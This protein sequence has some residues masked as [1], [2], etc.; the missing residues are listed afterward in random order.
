MAQSR[1]RVAR[2]PAGHHALL[3]GRTARR[4][5]P[6]GARRPGA[7]LRPGRHDRDVG[8]GH[9]AASQLFTGTCEPGVPGG[10]HEVGG[11]LVSSTAVGSRYVRME[12]ESR[13]SAGR[14]GWKFLQASPAVIWLRKGFRELRL[15]VA[16][17]CVEAAISGDR[18]LCFVP[19]GVSVAG[20]FVVD[21][22]GHY[23]VVILDPALLPARDLALPSAPMMAFENVAMTSGL[24]ELSELVGRRD[25]LVALSLEGWAMQ[26]T[27]RLSLVEGSTVDRP[28]VG[29]GL[30]DASAPCAGAH[31]G[32]ARPAGHDRRARRCRGVQPAALHSGVPEQRRS[33]SATLCVRV[34]HGGGSPPSGRDRAIHHLDRSRV[35]FRSCSTPQQFFP[36]GDGDESFAV[37]ATPP[38][39]IR[40]SG[41]TSWHFAES[42][43]AST[44]AELMCRD[45]L[46]ERCP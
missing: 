14:I 23:A 41:A 30:P 26:S 13:R 36:A 42:L 24:Q 17:R 25:D 5:F 37:P 1:R 15:D 43:R 8:R 28:G 11:E 21:A 32:Q 7:G 2:Q 27:A 4:A 3:R 34:A 31:Q 45:G 35:R 38:R 10:H 39:L 9:G 19:A 33:N 44:R 12:L 40:H 18:A 46:D 22:I 29:G 6:P 16:G 20:E